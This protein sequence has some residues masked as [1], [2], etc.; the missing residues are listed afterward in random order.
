MLTLEEFMEMRHTDCSP[1]DIDL[2]ENGRY[3]VALACIG[4]QNPNG[5]INEYLF[6]KYKHHR[7]IGWYIDDFY[8]TDVAAVLNIILE[9]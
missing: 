8:D 3:L 2:H 5:E 4:E 6:D 1:I 7:V 9:P